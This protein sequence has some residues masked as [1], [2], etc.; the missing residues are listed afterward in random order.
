ITATM[1]AGSTW[2]N[3]TVTNAQISSIS[4]TP[5]GV[6][7]PIGAQK[8]FTATGLFSDSTAQDITANCHWTSSN[9]AVATVGSGGGMGPITATGIGAGAANI[10]ASFGGVNGSST[11]TVSSATLVSLALSPASMILSPGSTAS[12]NAL[13]T[14]SDGSHVSVNGAVTWASSNPQVATIQQSG[15]VTGQS[16]GAT[17][18]KAQSG[19]ISATAGLVV[20]GA[21]LSSLQV[22]PASATV[23]DTI[24][25]GFTATGI[26]A[27]GDTLDLTGIAAWT[28]SAP[29]VA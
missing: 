4:V 23:P 17:P 20:E 10:N 13:G 1:G 28:S 22:S 29:S 5:T 6:T 12:Y 19:S 25:S 18:I 15:T 3:L 16:A 9:T 26:F 11:L 14:F 21:A 7:I 24:R 8:G 27:N 2:V